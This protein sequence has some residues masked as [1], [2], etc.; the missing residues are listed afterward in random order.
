M[1]KELKNKILN[2]FE[3]QTPDLKEKI[4]SE[5]EKQTQIPMQQVEKKERKHPF[6]F[7]RLVAVMSCL[8]IFGAGLIAG[9]N[10]PSPSPV[11]TAET[12]VYLDV[13]PSL[14]L[15][16]DQN[17]VVLSC[18]ATNEDAKII[19][20]G[21]TLDGVELKTALNAI[22]GSMYVKGYLSLTD[23]SMLIS[24][25]T[26]NPDDTNQYLSDITD[27]VNEVFTDSDMECAIIAQGLNVNE[28]LRR[29]AEEN[30]VSVGKMHLL[31]KMVE[32]IEDLTENDVSELSGMSIKDLNLLYSNNSKHEQETK[33]EVISGKV[34]V[35]VSND[36]ALSLVLSNISKSESDVEDYQI[37]VL[38]SKHDKIKV[39]YFVTIKLFNDKNA[40][41]Y[42]VDCK[43]GEVLEITKDS[44]T[45]PPKDNAHDNNHDDNHHQNPPDRDKR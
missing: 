25:E 3:S 40:Y 14:K 1:K 34:N 11:I 33:D 26:N 29:K 6:L 35:T 7:R 16:L 28:E 30:G 43:T 9:K 39:V 10:I 44:P 8:V 27:K 21:M 18:T 12:H 19:L 13:N 45:E 20:N 5:C 36:Q 37:F 2:A 32:N 4:I 22:V 15:S 42:E 38:P 17:N 23:N 31:E 24:V 41:T